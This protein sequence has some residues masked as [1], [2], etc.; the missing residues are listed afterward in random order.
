MRGVFETICE[1][2]FSMGQV[3]WPRP[4]SIIPPTPTL[5]APPPRSM[6]AATVR[7]V[8]EVV[9]VRGP[10]LDRPGSRRGPRRGPDPLMHILVMTHA[11]AMAA[12][13]MTHVG[14]MVSVM[15]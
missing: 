2:S 11:G 6:P 7:P 13:V 15:T 5:P 8:V 4:V 12:L 14:G 9:P 1:A 3:N 10:D